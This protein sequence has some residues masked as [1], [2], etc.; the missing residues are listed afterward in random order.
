MPS[1]TE[2]YDLGDITHLY[3]YIWTNNIGNDVSTLTIAQLQDA[4]NKAHLADIIAEGNSK[5]EIIDTGTGEIVGDIDGTNYLSIKAAETVF[6][7]TGADHDFRIE[8]NGNANVF[9]VNAG[10][11]SVGIGHTSPL[12]RFDVFPI[13][14]GFSFIAGSDLDQQARTDDHAKYVRIGTLHYDNDEEPVI[15]MTAYMPSGS[16]QLRI[17]GGTSVGNAVTSIS[18]YIATNSTTTTGTL[19][20]YIDSLGILQGWTGVYASTVGGTNRDLYIDN[21]GKIGYVSSAL[22]YKTN[23]VD[24]GSESEKIYDLRPV[25]FDYKDTSKGISQFGLIADE[26][27]NVL[28][29]IVS[30]EQIKVGKTPASDIEGCKPIL[31]TTSNPESVNYSKLI[32]LML[33]EIQKLNTKITNLEKTNNIINL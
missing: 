8:G 33:N 1:T 4:V 29:E 6:N 31:Q 27:V 10:N 24:L 28:P 7:E 20:G 18:F 25:K 19:A 23:I 17:G 5:L 15:L 16:N 9:Y 3:E 14:S 21:T 22:K 30:Y 32:P 2:T 13:Y 12:C 11:N 26:V